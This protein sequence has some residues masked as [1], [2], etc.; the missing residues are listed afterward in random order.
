MTLTM[1]RSLNSVMQRIGLLCT[2]IVA[3]L[4]FSTDLTAQCCQPIANAIPGFTYSYVLTNGTNAS[5]VAYNPNADLYYYVIAGNPTFPLETSDNAGVSLNQTNPGFDSRGLWWN[6]NLNQLE[7]NGFAA[8]GIWDFDLNGMQYA[9]NTGTSVFAGNNQPNSQSCGDLDYDANEIIYYDNGTIHRYDRATNAFLGTYPLTGIPV[10]TGSISTYTVAYTGCAGYEIGILDYVNKRFY[11]FD[12]S[13]GAYTGM[14]QLPAAAITNNSFRFSYAGGYAWTY[15]VGTRTWGSYQV[16]TTGVTNNINLGNDTTL[17]VGQTLTLDATTAG[18]TYTW[19][20]ASTNPTYTVTT[21]GTYYVDVDVAGCID[22]DTIN[23]SY[24]SG[25]SINLGNDTALCTG[26]TLTLDATTAGA[27]YTWQDAT[28]NPTFTVTSAGVYYVDVDVSGCLATDTIVVLYNT[29]PTVNLGNDTILCPGATL[30]LDATTAGATYTWQDATTNPTLTV[31]TD[32][33]YYVDV[34]L[35]GCVG[36][37]TI[38][39]TYAT[40]TPP[41]VTNDTVYCQGDPMI[42][43]I[44]TALA[45]GTI[46]WYSDLALT[47]NIGTGPN[48]M[49]NATLGQT[50]YFVTET[51]AGC[52]SNPAQI[53][54]TIVPPPPAPTV[55]G[56]A[57][58]CD[59]DPL[60]DLVAT[61]GLGG[62]INWYSDPA[63]TTN[64]GTGTTLTPTNTVGT[65]TYYVTES[66]GTCESAAA[67]VDVIINPTPAPPIPGNDTTYCIG[68][69]IGPI[70]ATAN[71]GGTL[72]WYSDAALT[73]NI[74]T[75][76]TVTPTSIIGTSTYY[77]TETINGCESPAAT[78]DVTFIAP[79]FALITGD[80]MICMGQSTT[81]FATGTGTSW[82]WNTGSNAGSITESPV[83]DTW[84]SVTYTNSCGSATDSVYVV[85]NPLP[86]G[87]AGPDTLLGF[88]NSVILTP[89][90]G[91][92]YL[93]SPDTGLDC[94]NCENPSA[95]PL[96]DIMYYV[97]VTD[98]NGC[99]AIDSVFIEVDGEVG[100]YV[101]NIFSPNGDGLNDV[102]YVRGNG[103]KSLNF[104]IYDRWGQMVFESTDQTIGWD[105][106][107]N[108]NP[109]NTAAFAYVVQVTLVTGDV[110]IIKGNVTLIR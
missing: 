29:A 62:T 91:T 3:L 93:W 95:S 100:V 40:L 47:M 69:P 108:G 36:T 97:I 51:V 48:L 72:N 110:E 85:V 105:G 89:S 38:L 35:G 86:V 82:S 13:N 57:T 50:N 26:Q 18:A 4:L 98:A 7:A 60:N 104:M 42:D 66:V 107:K 83:V 68:D 34:D 70:S 102:L 94:I 11:F 12:K 56:G 54:I 6:P 65:T 63:L 27:T 99:T 2:A 46:N 101:P 23:V 8:G 32:G 28:T 80:T 22:T 1:T 88:G 78:I 41:T 39:V 45:G 49:P 19:Q 71:G 15:D 79:P 109:M 59:G 81:L 58:Y 55:T 10:G 90:G 76:N 53:T 61:P 16:L 87:D 74:G 37:D 106:K 92:S 24:L 75:G 17:C 67:T 33:T 43:M 9:L 84:Y 20:D 21:A 96:E 30:T 5:G 44:A 14:S 31:T 52:E 64:I 77:V 25:G 103:I 73:T